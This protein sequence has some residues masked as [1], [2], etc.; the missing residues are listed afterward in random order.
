[1]AS[2]FFIVIEGLDGSGKSTVSKKLAAF[3]SKKRE[4][5]LTCEPSNSSYG[6]KL[7]KMLTEDS[8]PKAHAEQYLKLF[9]EDRKE[10]LKKEIEP[11]LA[12]G[13]TVVCDRFKHSTIAFQSLQGIP[14]QEIIS[15]HKDMISPDVTFILDLPPSV[16]FERLKRKKQ[17]F[18]QQH[19]MRSLR[20]NY[21]KL[22]KILKGEKIVIVDA[23]KNP[24]RVFKKIVVELNRANLFRQT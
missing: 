23:S 11:A 6:K 9:V 13:K 4:V 14:L 3:L 21:L 5:L 12:Q 1:M 10:H 15:L 22:P 2:G 8:D 18:E 24:E 19:F 16:A 7:R 20:Q 17:K